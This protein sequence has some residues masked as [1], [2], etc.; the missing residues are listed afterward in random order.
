MLNYV[1]RGISKNEVGP[2]KEGST[3]GDNKDGKGF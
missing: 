3:K 1:G 2:H